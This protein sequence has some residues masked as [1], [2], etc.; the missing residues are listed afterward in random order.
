MNMSTFG[1]FYSSDG[2]VIVASNGPITVVFDVVPGGLRIDEQQTNVKI[3]HPNTAKIALTAA[4]WH[5][6]ASRR[7]RLVTHATPTR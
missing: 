5:R 2:K 3:D 6:Q 4:R 1:F 7:S